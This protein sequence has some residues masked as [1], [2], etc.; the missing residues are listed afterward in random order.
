MCIAKVQ[1][2]IDILNKGCKILTKREKLN[3]IG[4]LKDN[5]GYT[6]LSIS[7]PDNFIVKAQ[8]LQTA[9]H[10]LTPY[11]QFIHPFRQ[12]IQTGSAG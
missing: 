4:K 9:I 11:P 12:F 7:L 3:K 10:K 1:K 5:F 6:N 2:R 8:Y